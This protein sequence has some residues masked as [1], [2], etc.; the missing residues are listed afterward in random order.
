MPVPTA[1]TTPG[2]ALLTGASRGLGLTLA[3]YLATRRWHLVMNARDSAPLASVASELAVL[4][5]V[6][7]V[8]G[9]VADGQVRERLAQAAGDRLELLVNNASDLGSTPLPALVEYELERLRRVF[10]TNAIAPLAMVQVTLPALRRAGGRVVNI[11]SDAARGGY[12]GWGGYGAS[13]AALELISLTLAQEL[14]GVT[15]MTVDPGD[16]RT[17]MH[18]A[19]FPNEDISDRIL[20]EETLPFWAWLLEQGPERLSGRRFEAQAEIWQAV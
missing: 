11:S 2:T 3:R 5:E 14:E 20:P 6:T 4:T 15:V 8:A 9:D 13:K 18:Q 10:E 17:A 12:P 16:M 19:A 7:V 1:A